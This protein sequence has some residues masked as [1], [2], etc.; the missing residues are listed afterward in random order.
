MFISYL[1]NILCLYNFRNS[2]NAVWVT[3]GKI[4]MVDQVVSNF[5]QATSR[6]YILDEQSLRDGPGNKIIK[7]LN[8]H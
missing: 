5:F 3:G 8:L 6:T 1:Q 4:H 7:I 2:Q